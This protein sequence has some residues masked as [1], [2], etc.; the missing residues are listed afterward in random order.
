MGDFHEERRKMSFEQVERMLA[1]DVT[2]TEWCRLNHVA[3]STMYHWL[4]V[5]C[6]SG[7]DDGRRTERNEIRIREVLKQGGCFAVNA[8]ELHG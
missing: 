2:V 1:S 4:K 8:R 3:K 5:Y 7:N 6:E